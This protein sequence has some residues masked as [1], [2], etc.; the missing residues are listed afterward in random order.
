[1]SIYRPHGGPKN[2]GPGDWFMYLGHFLIPAIVLFLAIL[3]CS[4]GGEIPLLLP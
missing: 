3:L 4:G 2:Q 1:M